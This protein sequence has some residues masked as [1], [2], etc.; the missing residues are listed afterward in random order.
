M[1]AKERNADVGERQQKA[2]SIT[3]M[4]LHYKAAI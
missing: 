3:A 1:L 2:S 4:T